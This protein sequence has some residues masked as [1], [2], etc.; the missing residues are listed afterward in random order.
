MTGPEAP[1]TLMRKPWQR[2]LAELLGTFALVFIGCGAAI[3]NSMTSGTVT[4]VGVALAFGFVVMAMVYALGP[5]SAAHFNPAVTVGFAAARRF[6]W[7]HV[8]AY[9]TA[10]CLGAVG[11]SFTHQQLFSPDLAA[12]AAYG[13]T[14][15]TVA[16]PMAFAF[17][18]ILTGILMTVIMAVATDRRVTG[19][20]PGLSI[21]VTVAFCALAFGPVTGASMNPARSLG[22]AL[23]AGGSVL[24]F[25]PIYLLAPPVGAVAAALVYELMRDGPHHAQPAPADLE[26]AMR[27]EPGLSREP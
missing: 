17:E 4:H 22:P 7:R 20:V 16:G 27:A 15:P 9:V 5:I 13:A 21:G 2:Y 14:T 18:T 8:P 3:T 11:A 12:R 25:L 10:Q 26:E 23:L 6:P 1:V 24:E 19:A